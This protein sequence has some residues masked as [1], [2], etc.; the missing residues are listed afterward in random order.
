MSA[1]MHFGEDQLALYSTFS[2]FEVEKLPVLDA[3]EPIY[4]F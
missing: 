4:F 1:K 3:L 2:A